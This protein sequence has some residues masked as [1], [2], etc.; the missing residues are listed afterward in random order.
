M[1]KIP[2]SE[3]YTDIVDFHTQSHIVIC[4][5][6]Y[7]ANTILLMFDKQ[8]CMYGFLH[9]GQGLHEVNHSS[10]G[11]ITLLSSASHIKW[12]LIPGI[13]NKGYMYK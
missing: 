12:I 8:P 2:Y 3:R 9:P 13:R 7:R 10:L 5:F 11:S 1:L 6:L 4:Y